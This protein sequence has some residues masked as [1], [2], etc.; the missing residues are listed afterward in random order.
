MYIEKKMNCAMMPLGSNI[1][2]KNKCVKD[3]IY[4]KIHNY[5]IKHNISKVVQCLQCGMGTTA[6]HKICYKCGGQNVRQKHR[7]TD[8]I[9]PWRE[10]IARLN[11]IEC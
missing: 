8:V 4:C 3:S 10:E 2:C 9:K 5:I 7:Y 6:K 11:K 1:S